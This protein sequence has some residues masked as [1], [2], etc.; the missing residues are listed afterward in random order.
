MQHWLN[1][2][3]SWDDLS[4]AQQV[5]WRTGKKA[6][7]E[8]T[9]K[10]RGFDA[11]A[12]LKRIVHR[13]ETWQRM[14]EEQ[15]KGRHKAQIITKVNWASDGK[16]YDKIYHDPVTEAFML[17]ENA[18]KEW[19]EMV[20]LWFQHTARY[21]WLSWFKTLDHDEMIA[22]I[23]ALEGPTKKP[24]DEPPLDVPGY[25][26]YYLMKLIE[27]MVVSEVSGKPKK[28]K[29]LPPPVPKEVKEAHTQSTAGRLR[30]LPG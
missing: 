6:F 17:Y 20:N 7:D 12:H 15:K 5:L 3:L 29:E 18:S 1:N 24:K 30:R 22:H 26:N 16:R 2:V 27:S 28:Q 14:E 25:I 9:V 21:D 11:L 19:G 10:L 8:A 4:P 13:E 23:N